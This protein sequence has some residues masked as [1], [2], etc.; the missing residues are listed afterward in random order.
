MDTRTDFPS[1]VFREKG[2]VVCNNIYFWWEETG[3]V[4]NMNPQLNQKSVPNVPT[5]HSVERYPNVMKTNTSKYQA[6]TKKYLNH[7]I[8]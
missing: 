3:V 7:F 2:V 6:T 5:H 1:R 8:P 4:Q